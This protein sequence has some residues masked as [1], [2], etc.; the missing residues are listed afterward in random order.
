M[1]S[2]ASGGACR[3]LLRIGDVAGRTGLSLRTIRYYEQ[4]GL[5][6]PSERSAG[7]FRLYRDTAVARLLLIQQMKPLEFTLEQM[8]ELLEVLDEIAGPA[9]QAHRGP[10]LR[11]A[12]RVHDHRVAE[13]V[14][15]L[16]RRLAEAEAFRVSLA[17]RLR[18]PAGCLD[19][20]DGRP[21]IDE[22]RT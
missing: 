10:A 5:L 17:A 1:G 9:G 8:R 20:G 13:R 6:P 22:V 12:L 14:A 15:Q 21:D 4:V 11:A 19:D 2:T 3:G 16:Q 7:G 18:G